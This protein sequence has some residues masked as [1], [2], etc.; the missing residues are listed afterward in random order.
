MA[1][2]NQSECKSIIRHYRLDWGCKNKQKPCAPSETK[3]TTTYLHLSLL[4]W[5]SAAVKEERLKS[6]RLV[7]LTVTYF[8]SSSSWVLLSASYVLK[9]YCQSTHIPSV[10]GVLRSNTKQT[11]IILFSCKSEEGWICCV[12]AKCCERENF[13]PE[14]RHWP[15]YIWETLRCLPAAFQPEPSKLWWMLVH[16]ETKMSA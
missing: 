14:S 12:S 7:C 6:Q 15:T 11:C 10:I 2:L 8:C 16:A 3:N 9:I 13:L 4:C 5:G 1:L